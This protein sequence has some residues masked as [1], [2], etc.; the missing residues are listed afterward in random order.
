LNLLSEILIGS[1]NVIKT[2]ALPNGTAASCRA[3]H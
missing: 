3:I 2:I 1:D